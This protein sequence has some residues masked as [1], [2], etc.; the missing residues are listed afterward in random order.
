MDFPH[1][2]FFVLETP[3]SAVEVVLTMVRRTSPVKCELTPIIV[4]CKSLDGVK[5]R[6]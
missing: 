3:R 4:D 1:F 6:N 5:A 2:P